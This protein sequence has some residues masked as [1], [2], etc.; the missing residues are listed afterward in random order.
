[1][2]SAT[3]T[4]V[5]SSA[6]FSPEDSGGLG[7]GARALAD[8]AIDAKH[9]FA[10]LAE[11][12][13]DGDGGLAGLPVAQ[14]QLALAASD[15]DERVDDLEARLE[16]HGDGGASHDG[17]GGTFGRQTFGGWHRAEAVERTAERVDDAPEQTVAHG[18]VHDAACAPDFV[19][20][21]QA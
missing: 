7:H 16:G 4:T 8:G 1:M 15:R 10:A 5:Y 13:V 9:V 12:R 3:T 2:P 14:D 6:P 19:A 21:V 20:G 17:G 18:Y 11:D